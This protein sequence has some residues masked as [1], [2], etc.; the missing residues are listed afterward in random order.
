[1]RFTLSFLCF[2]WSTTVF[3]QV[4]ENK[5]IRPDSTRKIQVVEAACGQCQFGLPGKGCSLAVRMNGK[6]YFVDGTDIDSHGDAHASDGF[7]NAKRSAEVQGI[8]VNN[9]FKASY[10]KLVDLPTTAPNGTKK[11]QS[12]Q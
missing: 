10:F 7:C 3:A 6:T 5:Q 9:R 11:A 2:F 1:M 4:T 12:P 8:V